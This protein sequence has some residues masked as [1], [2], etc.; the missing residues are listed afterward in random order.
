MKWTPNKLHKRERTLQFSKYQILGL[1]VHKHIHL[2]PM[3]MCSCIFPYTQL[4]RQYD[5]TYENWFMNH[6]RKH[7]CAYGRSTKNM[8]VLIFAYLCCNRWALT[9]RIV[10]GKW[11]ISFDSSGKVSVQGNDKPNVIYLLKKRGLSKCCFT[12]SCNGN[13]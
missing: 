10:C 11:Q 2:N 9:L 5:C 13:L 12:I 8:L 4:L 7:H 6:E 1:S 3:V